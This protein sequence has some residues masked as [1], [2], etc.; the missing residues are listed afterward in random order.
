MSLAV[1]E[2]VDNFF[3]DLL[4]LLRSNK[5][6]HTT[7]QTRQTHTHSAKDIAKNDIAQ[8]TRGADTSASPHLTRFHKRLQFYGNIF[9]PMNSMTHCGP[10]D[11]N[12]HSLL[13]N[14]LKY[15]SSV[16][17]DCTDV[18]TPIWVPRWILL[19]SFYS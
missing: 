6:P 19:R 16:Q 17:F 9:H 2:R 5:T 1:F 14:F 10:R 8:A 12:I 18:D 7:P 3:L 13:H 11:T 4:P 15:I